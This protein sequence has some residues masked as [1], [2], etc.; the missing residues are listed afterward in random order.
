MDSIKTFKPFDKVLVRENNND[1]WK[2]DLFSHSVNN[3]LC[4]YVCV[5]SWYKQS[6]PYNEETA[7]LLG[8]TD[9]YVEPY[10]PEDGDFLYISY[11]NGI[12]Y[13]IIS[14]E[15]EFG[16][17]AYAKL[18][19]GDKEANCQGR[20]LARTTDVE[21]RPA[22]DTE[23]QLL[24][25]ALHTAGKDWDADKKEIVEYRWKPKEGDEYFYVTPPCGV[26]SYWW[27]GKAADESI[28]RYGNCFRTKEE[29]QV[30]AE[31]FKKL[32]KGE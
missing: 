14:K 24:I 29:A 3:A 1:M 16:I 6:I 20:G 28:Y 17:G 21:I 31:K 10:V 11:A 25:D 2:C 7:H 15:I 22:T 26:S 8:T 5:G 23:K 4:K 30:M 27:N 18:L 19:E 13:T 12:R 32:L 9:D